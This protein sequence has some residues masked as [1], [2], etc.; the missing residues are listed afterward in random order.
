MAVTVKQAP[1]TGPYSIAGYGKHKG[2]TPLA[3]KRAMSRMGFLPWDPAQWDLLFN[4]KLETALD[5]WDP[6][7]DGYADGRWKKLR[8]AKVP[9]GIPN[10]GQP[11]LDAECCRLIQEEWAAT[12]VVVP[13]L[14]PVYNGGASVLAY[15]LTHATSGI[16]L[17]P[18]FDTAFARY[19]GIIAPE[20]MTVTDPSSADYGEAFFCAGT[21]IDWWF[22]HL[23]R[24]HPAGRKFAKG[25][26]IGR[27]GYH[28]SPHCH[29]G[30]NVERMWGAGKQ[31]VHHTNYTHGAPLIGDQLRGKL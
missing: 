8:A 1:Y 14:G 23:D 10:A 29:V 28:P 27:V 5:K 13:D 11:A 4:A 9:A 30:I 3:L 2:N 22:G 18:A 6:G 21:R 25:D 26:L 12:R 7:K 20:A 16:P 19:T 24:N 15:D 17:Y 31:L